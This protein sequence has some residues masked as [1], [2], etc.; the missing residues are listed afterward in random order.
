LSWPLL[1]HD[2]PWYIV[3]P[4][5]GLCPVALYAVANKHLGASA[6]Y[7]QMARALVGRTTESWRAYYFLGLVIGAVAAAILQGGPRFHLGYQFIYGWMPLW[8]AVGVL[9]ASGLAMGYGAR[10]AGGC[11]SGHGLCG[12]SIR[13]AGSL[14]TAVTFFAIA[15]AISLVLNWVTGGRA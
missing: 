2:L 11:T 8:G 15:V 3:G 14:A 9:L 5:L 7:S 4:L 10:W 6:A 1:P 12:M 13:S